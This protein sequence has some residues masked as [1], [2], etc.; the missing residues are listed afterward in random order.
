MRLIE[1][2]ERF[3]DSDDENDGDRDVVYDFSMI[4]TMTISLCMFSERLGMG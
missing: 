3:H 1:L 2:P 4:S